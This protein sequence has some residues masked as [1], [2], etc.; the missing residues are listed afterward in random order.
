MTYS[1]KIILTAIL[2]FALTYVFLYYIDLK[3]NTILSSYIDSEV[4]KVAYYVVDEVIRKIDYNHFSDILSFSH[5]TD[6]EIENISYNTVKINKLKNEILLLSKNEFLNI[7]KGIINDNYL[8]QQ[9][10]GKEKFKYIKKGY[11]CDVS[12]SSIRGSTLFGNVGSS[13]PI[14][15]SFMG[16]NNIDIDVDVKEY[17]I[18]NVIVQLYIILNLNSLVSMPL[19]TKNHSVVIREPVSIE[20]IKGSIPDSYFSRN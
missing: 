7:E 1:K 19:S 14:R 2:V 20:L 15:L 17:G 16:Y 9:Q 3:L 5:G 6:G 10:L 12:F 11:L 8:V 18:N 4:E 13:I